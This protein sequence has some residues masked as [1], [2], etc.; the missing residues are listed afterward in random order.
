MT[1]NKTSIPVIILSP[2]ELV[3]SDCTDV[4]RK[5]KYFTRYN[6]LNTFCGGS[7]DLNTEKRKKE[8][9]NERKKERSKEKEIKRREKRETA[10]R[11]AH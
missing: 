8:R 2:H 5:I 6:T 10:T 7:K 1:K 11:K 4:I 3:C 9:K